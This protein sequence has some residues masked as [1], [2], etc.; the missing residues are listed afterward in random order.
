MYLKWKTKEDWVFSVKVGDI[1]CT[2]KYEHLKVV[3]IEEPYEEEQP[4][5]R[6]AILENGDMCLLMHCAEPV[7]HPEGWHT[8]PDNWEE[9]WK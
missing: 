5:E 2:C 4:Y 3:D 9:E 7:P 1:I 8:Y 6:L